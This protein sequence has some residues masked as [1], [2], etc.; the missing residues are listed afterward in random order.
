MTF[1]NTDELHKVARLFPGAKLVVR[2]LTDDS[3]S[4][5]RLGVKF[6]APL[7]DVP[8]LLT[9]A[10]GLGLDV[11]GV[12]FH[13]GSGCSDPGAF[14]DAISRA[15]AAFVYGREAGYRF[16]LLDVGGGF[17]DHTFELT[18]NVINDA[19]AFYF[20]KHQ[21][22]ADGM[23]VIAEPGRFY[24]STAFSL[25]CNIIARRVRGTDEEAAVSLEDTENPRTMCE[26]CLQSIP[27]VSHADILLRGASVTCNL[28]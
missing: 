7:S 6:G 16:S 14:R 9:C 15:H 19:L 28:Y 20:P 4:L 23:R 25:A 5:C 3:S 2:I 27:R 1:D 24:V 8:R 12:S 17:E 26:L 11:V 10:R 22:E 21:R 18:A 13:V